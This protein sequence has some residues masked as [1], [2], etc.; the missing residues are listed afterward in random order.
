MQSHD[1]RRHGDDARPLDVRAGGDRRRPSTA[2]PR[3]TARPTRATTAAG[4][5]AKAETGARDDRDA[6]RVHV[7]QRRPALPGAP[8]RRAAS[9]PTTT[10]PTATAQVVGGRAAGH[11][12]LRRAGPAAPRRRRDLHV[13][14]RGRA[15][16]PRATRPAT[17]T[18]RLR[19]ARRADRGHAAGRRRDRRTSIDADGRRVARK[20][21]GA[22]RARLPLPAAGSSRS[23]SSTPTARSRSRFVYV[24]ALERPRP[25]GAA[26]ARP[27]GSSPTRSAARGLVVD[28]ANGAVAQRIDYDEF[29]R[30]TARLGNPASSRSA[31]PAGCC[32][33]DTGLVRFGARDYDPETGRF[34]APDPLRFGGGGTNLYGYALAD[35]VNLD[36]PERPDPGH[37]PGHRVHRSTTVPDRQGPDERVRAVRGERGGLRCRPGRDLHP[38]CDRRR[39]RGAR[40]RGGREGPRRPLGRRPGRGQGRAHARRP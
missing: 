2:R 29:G 32:D 39:P 30:V 16:R 1:R 23:P 35:P 27:T 36:R 5:R 12:H 37:D 38:G 34:T 31:S 25:D 7:R 40:H 8:E 20:R 14:G 26:T 13:H 4:S 17:T 9:R 18:L 28:T 15:R 10:T 6:L 11:R 22:R 3:S 21:D 19:R 33:R 24:D